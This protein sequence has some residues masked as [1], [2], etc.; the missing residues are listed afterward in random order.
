MLYQEEQ[1]QELLNKK[2]FL[3]HL[4]SEYKKNVF[5]DEIEED[6]HTIKITNIVDEI[7]YTSVE[8]YKDFPELMESYIKSIKK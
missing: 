5:K 6:I 7:I 8:I 1:I 2:G 3:E 4:I